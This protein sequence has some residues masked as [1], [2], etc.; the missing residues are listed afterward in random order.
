MADSSVRNN[1][2]DPTAY[3]SGLA[4]MPGTMIPRA[5]KEGQSLAFDPNTPRN[6]VVDP[7]EDGGGFILDM[8]SLSTEKQFNQAAMR[9]G[10]LENPTKFYRDMSLS[11]A[12]KAKVKKTHQHTTQLLTPDNPTMMNE[13]PVP[14]ISLLSP[15]AAFP[16]SA[17]DKLRADEEAMEIRAR[18]FNLELELQ[19]LQN[20]QDTVDLQK[21]D[22]GI[23]RQ[24]LAQLRAGFNQLVEATNQL[25][26]LATTKEHKVKAAVQPAV[27]IKPEPEPEPVNPFAG[28][29]IPF[30]IGDKAQRPQY[31]TYF[32][33]TKMGTMAARYHA[34]VEGQD[35]L[36]LVYDT[37]FEDGFQYLPPNLGEE[38]IKISVPKLGSKSYTCSS[39]GLHWTI[40]CLDIIILIVV[41]AGEE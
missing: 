28:L 25:I 12:E 35:C 40:G 11:I 34:V 1:S 10:V 30:L 20:E 6:V 39:L 18:Q 8:S 24:E 38:R 23:N 16:L 27:E 21:G 33:M 14:P 26:K 37:R 29:L 32:E 4:G 13:L 2:P 5:G 15:L 7:G 36:A 9:A 41:P 19:R 17:A 3:H 31:E 22:A